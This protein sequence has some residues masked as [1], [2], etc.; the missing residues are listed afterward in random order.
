MKRH[1]TRIVEPPGVN[2][3]GLLEILALVGMLGMAA[4]VET[5]PKALTAMLFFSGVLRVMGFD[6]WW[7]LGQPGLNRWERLLSPYCGGCCRL[8]PVWLVPP[9]FLAAFTALIIW[10]RF[11]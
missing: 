9:G 1:L 8:A 3:L 2:I 6:V 10:S 7:R 5:L 4:S 11:K